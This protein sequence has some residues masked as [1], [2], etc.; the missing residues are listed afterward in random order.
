MLPYQQESLLGAM[1]LSKGKYQEAI[2]H[3]ENA[4]RLAKSNGI[5]SSDESFEVDYFNLAQSKKA[6]QRY[7]EAITDFQKVLTINP[8]NE[9]AYIHLTK[10]C[11]EVDTQQTIEIAINELNNCTGYFPKNI[12]AFMNKGIAYLKLGENIKAKSA[13]QSA[14]SLG[15]KDADNFIRDYCQ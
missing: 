4:I 2:I 15:N 5:N 6:M 12:S 1:A 13:F 8:K 9:S 7:A 3:L 14:K 11:F 10:C